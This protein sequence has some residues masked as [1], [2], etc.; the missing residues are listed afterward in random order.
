[1]LS[2]KWAE[3]VAGLMSSVPKRR[4][5][6]LVF[7]GICVAASWTIGVHQSSSSVS[8][9]TGASF[10]ALALAAGAWFLVDTFRDRP[11]ASTQRLPATS[12]FLTIRPIGGQHVIGI[13]IERGRVVYGAL[14][15]AGNTK[16]PLG[17]IRVSR[18]CDPRWHPWTRPSE[19]YDAAARGI[20]EILDKVGD[21]KIDGIGIGMPGLVDITRGELQSSPTNL[22][23]GHIPGEIATALGKADRAAAHRLGLDVDINALAKSVGRYIAVDN[24]ARC[25]GR[26][27][28]NAHPEPGSFLSMYVGKGIG[29]AIVLNGELYFGSHGFAGE[30]GH[31]VL[32]LGKRVTLQGRGGWEQDME[33]TPC[34]CQ[35]RGFHYETLINDTGLLRLAGV[36]DAE[37]LANLQDQLV[38]A[39][40]FEGDALLQC[41]DEVLSVDGSTPL[42]EVCK[43]AA[44]GDYRRALN[45][46]ERLEDIYV[47]LLTMGI[48]NAVNMLDLDDVYL[49]GPIVESFDKLPRFRDNL[50]RSLKRYLFRD[51]RVTLHIEVA[52]AQHVWVGAGLV[53]RDSGYAAALR[54]PQDPVGDATLDLV[55]VD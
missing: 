10:A 30:C 20:I 21:R 6:L 4:R 42:G 15:L 54:L 34:K 40:T 8:L 24:D 38:E 29:S 3:L 9:T 33:A 31:Q 41:A 25:V 16:E 50:K 18:V 52:A 22:R 19:A 47:Q 17:R 48:A 26:F 2:D 12:G 36:I 1:M 32:N 46:F 55:S 53:F 44:K 11:R 7:M 23:P 51:D 45:F 49:T 43:R 28:L 37:F 5:P 39:G 13:S 14:E 27:L 35:R